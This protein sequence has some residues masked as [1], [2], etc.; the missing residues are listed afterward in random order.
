MKHETD[1]DIVQTT[2]LKP[3][4]IMDILTYE[5][6]SHWLAARISNPLLQSLL[7][8]YFAWKVRRKYR[9]Y[10]NSITIR[11]ILLNK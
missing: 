2:N 10:E 9:R 3:I 7:G 5:V 4:P 1:H 8:Y 6:H 11:N